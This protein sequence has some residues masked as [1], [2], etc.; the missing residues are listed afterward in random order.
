MGCPAA[1][2]SSDGRRKGTTPFGKLS[3]EAGRVLVEGEDVGAVEQP[4]E[5]GGDLGGSAEGE[6]SL[7]EPEV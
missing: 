7:I 4:V 1:A 2:T 5:R 6:V 3:A